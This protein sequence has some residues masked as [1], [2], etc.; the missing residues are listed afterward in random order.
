MSYK[1]SF[2]TRKLYED[3][4]EKFIIKNGYSPNTLKMQR[5][6]REKRVLKQIELDSIMPKGQLTFESMQKLEN[7]K[8][9]E[10]MFQS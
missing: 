5:A 2:V 8:S 6:K 3:G 9:K 1:Q 4:T 7:E 10:N